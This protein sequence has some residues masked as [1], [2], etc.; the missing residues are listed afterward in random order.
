MTRFVRSSRA[1]RAR[2]SSKSRRPIREGWRATGDGRRIRAAL[3]ALVVGLACSRGPSPAAAPAPIATTDSVGQAP[4]GERPVLQPSDSLPV[5]QPNDNRLFA[6]SPRPGSVMLVRLVARRARWYPSGPEHNGLVAETFGEEGAAARIPGP[7]IRVPTATEVR[8]RIRNLLPDTMVLCGL[9]R[10]DCAGGDTLRIPPGRA[11]EVHF[12]ATTPG[13]WVYLGGVVKDGKTHLGG[14]RGQLVGAVIIDPPKPERDRVFVISEWEAPR[15]S[16]NPAKGSFYVPVINGRSWPYTERFTFALGDSVRW[17]IVNATPS[18]HPMHLHGFYF[19]VTGRGDGH[20]D[21]VYT[22]ADR[23]SVV[24]ENV[25][26]L[27]SSSILW[28]PERAGNWLFHCHKVFHISEWINDNIALVKQD[29]VSYPAHETATHAEQGMA[30]LAVGITVTGPRQVVSNAGRRRYRLI[31]QEKARVYG[32]EPAYGFVLQTGREEPAPDSVVVPGPPLL[33]SRGQP[34]AI[35]VVNRLPVPTSIHWHGIELDSYYDGAAGWS[36]DSARLAPLI[37]PGDSFVVRFTPPR[38]GTFIYHSHVDEIRQ[39]TTG[40]YGA[41]IVRNTGEA[42]DAERD[43]V[44]LYA[45]AGMGLSDTARVELNGST[46]PTFEWK[47]GRHRMRFIGMIADDWA[48]IAL[49]S[50]SGVVTWRP[51]AKDGALVPRSQRADTPAQLHL[52]TGETYDF[53]VIL[54][55]GDYQ[56]EAKSFTNVLATIR[57]R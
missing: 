55:A 22:G 56:L 54:P 29:Q 26:P 20:G 48:N 45:Q 43:H 44:M 10:D 36:G 38:A 51:A 41:L 13:T 3:A 34:V 46:A 37:A 27:H 17:R 19:R 52:A 2:S 32:D 50:D 9:P 7:I 1:K 39:L 40:M 35:T 49:R 11:P 47:P 5:A 23:Q 33:L 12:A 24:T 4:P 28:V 15:D 57:V 31:V 8:V 14:V 30:G 21:T 16:A 25:L 42:Y 53:D 18:E 6:G